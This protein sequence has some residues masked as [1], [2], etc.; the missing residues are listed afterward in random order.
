MDPEIVLNFS[1]R[2]IREGALD[3]I[4]RPPDLAAANKPSHMGVV[5]MWAQAERRT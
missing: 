4:P 2:N 1:E 5:T 3:T